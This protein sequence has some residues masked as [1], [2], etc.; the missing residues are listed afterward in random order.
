MITVYLI[1]MLACLVMFAAIAVNSVGLPKTDKGY[2]TCAA[3]FIMLCPVINTVIMLIG[4][5][6][7]IMMFLDTD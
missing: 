3:V 1:S 5:W 4:V 6:G 7:G 2:L